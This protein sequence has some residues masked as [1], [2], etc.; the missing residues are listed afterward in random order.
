MQRKRTIL[1]ISSAES[2]M[3]KLPMKIFIKLRISTILNLSILVYIILVLFTHPLESFAQSSTQSG[4][5]VSS[6]VAISIPIS[7]QNATDGA[8]ISSTARGYMLSNAAYDPTVYGVITNNPA[9]LVQ[10]TE[11]TNYKSVLTLGK[12][13]TQVSTVNGTIKK[14]DFI[15]TSPIAG[16]GQVAKSNGFI[17]GTALENYMETDTKKVGKILV[18]INPH[19]NG[20]FIGIRSNLIQVLKDARSAF[21]LS[22]LAS[23]RY[24]LSAFTTIAAFIL[25]FIYFGRVARTGVEA[26]GRNPLAAKLIEL[27]VVINV[28]L[29]I[30]IIAVGLG[31]AYLILIL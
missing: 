15:T 4:R 19:Y 12:V 23:F 29:T 26:L 6:G 30:V 3:D 27:G 21:T 1:Y 25:G 5:I 18:S 24:L 9:V 14:N 31:I 2:V 7:D 8:I 20:S 10:N 17:V 22:P 11:S 28:L 16:V 13:L